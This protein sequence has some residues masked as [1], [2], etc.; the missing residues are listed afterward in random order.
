ME[1]IEQAAALHRQAAAVVQAASQALDDHVPLPRTDLA[2]QHELALRLRQAAAKLTPGWL[3]ASLDKVDPGP[4]GEQRRPEFVRIGSGQPLDDVDFPAVI[5][6]LGAGHLTFSA[7]SRDPRVAG[8]LRSILLRLLATAPAGTLIVRAVD[9]V[10]GALFAPFA[11]LADAGLMPPA[12]TDRAGLQTILSEAEHWVRPSRPTDQRR[13]TARPRRRD[14]T[15]LLLIASLPSAVTSED[16][17]RI[18]G[19]AQ[20]GPAAGL[21][22]IIAGWP[23]M[24]LGPKPP[25]PPLPAST[26]VSLRTEYTLLGGMPFTTMTPPAGPSP[27]EVWPG[28]SVPVRLDPDPPARLTQRVCSELAEK[29]AA[30]GQTHLMDLLPDPDQW[31]AETSGDGLSTTVGLAGDTPVSLHFTDLTPHWL[32]GGRAG[33]GKTGFLINVLYGLCTR[34]DPDELQLYLLDFSERGALRQFT[35]TEEDPSWLPHAV[36]VGVDSGPESGLAVLR[37]LDRELTRRTAILN[38]AGATRF[39]QL[40]AAGAPIPRIVCVIDEFQKLLSTSEEIAAE[41]STLLESLSRAGRSA[42]MHLIMCSQNAR[43][44]NLF[45]QF[46]V[47]VAL[48]GGG[49]VLEATNDSAASLPM[50]R[51]VV[52]TAGGLGGPRGATRGHEK[53]VRFPDPHADEQVLSALRQRLWQAREP[54]S[55]PP[56][57]HASSHVPV[58]R[59][60]V[61]LM[62]DG[63]THE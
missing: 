42:G 22:L 6:L 40:R 38:D 21:H 59:P 31:W 17:S 32:V 39:H 55:A 36:E 2:E 62:P 58:P 28:L 49:D 14:C 35:P 56:L 18:V 61:N 15:M 16:L 4:L 52:N 41:A 48:P 27:T 23:P 13:P 43:S 46:L 44:S 11:A 25:L 9:A 30:Q 12:V 57:V 19:L 24:P 8:A 33:S 10:G 34:Y 29:F 20:A 7:D 5:P 50:G 1:R 45:G 63:V 51:A 47:R 54:A 26:Q 37:S 3:G 60:P 53:T